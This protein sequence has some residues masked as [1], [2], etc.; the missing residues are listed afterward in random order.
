MGNCLLRTTPESLHEQMPS[1]GAEGT[2]WITAD[3]RL[4]NRDDLIGE[5]G[6]RQNPASE[7]P[8]ST[9]ILEAFQKW[10][11]DCPTHLLGD[12]AFAIWDRR[13]QTLFCARDQFGI[14]PFYYSPV[15]PQFAFCSCIDGLLQLP[16]IPRR[17][18]ERR[19]ASY[20]TRFFGDT[21][22]TF[23]ED[24][25]RLPPAHALRVNE[26]GVRL[27][28]YWVLSR[29]CETHFRSDEQCMEA[30]QAL[31]REAV[32]TRLRRV[33]Q[34][35]SM[36]SGGLDS[37]SISA[38]AGRLVAEEGQGPLATFSAVFDEVPRTNERRFIDAAVEHCGFEPSYLAADR[39]DPF[40]APPELDGTQVEA[41]YAPNLFLHWGL[42][43][44][45]KK[46][47]VRVV[48]D[49]FDGDEYP[50]SAWSRLSRGTGAGQ[51]VSRT[52]PAGARCSPN[53]GLF[54]AGTLVGSRL[55]PRITAQNSFQNS[56]GRA[57]RGAALAPSE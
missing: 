42:Y 36:L 9:I 10:G 27:T 2:C 48:L 57:R 38:V 52:E 14:K 12:F 32:R 18:N 43:S 46:R 6:L 11:E 7:I 39:C 4:D 41:H 30:F 56:S 50:V 16:W 22:A 47:G 24:I 53:L 44:M 20:L 1:S 8:D 49:G 3:A 54:R 5:L 29:S 15:G 28:R 19:L 13:N 35:G 21:A 51:S 55:A 37:S 23:Y 33:G 34:A 26:Q 40:L 25:L 17:L 45:A 31:F